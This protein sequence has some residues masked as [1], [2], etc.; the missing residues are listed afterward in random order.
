MCTSPRKDAVNSP[1]QRHQT[2]G[3][4]AGQIRIQ[5][6]SNMDRAA[7]ELRLCLLNESLDYLYR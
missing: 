6:R 1:R 5:R 4:V 2:R 7:K 3:K